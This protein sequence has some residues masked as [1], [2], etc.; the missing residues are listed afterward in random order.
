M[1]TRDPGGLGG[2]VAIEEGERLLTI[3]GTTNALESHQRWDGATG[4]STLT[5]IRWRPTV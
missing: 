1:N 2:P 4:K 3:A 5:A